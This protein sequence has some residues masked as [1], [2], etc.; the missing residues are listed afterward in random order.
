MGIILGG[1]QTWMEC[2]CCKTKSKPS[3]NHNEAVEWAYKE[4]WCKSETTGKTY[5]PTC[6]RSPK[7]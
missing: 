6:S 3:Y 7:Q 4:L 2:D 1:G 5:C